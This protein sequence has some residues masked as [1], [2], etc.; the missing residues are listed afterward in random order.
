MKTKDKIILVL[1][2][3][4]AAFLWSARLGNLPLWED[5][6]HT[7]LLGKSILTHPLPTAWDGK[8]L[9]SGVQAE[10]FN[11]NYV[12]TWD[13][14][15][16]FYLTAASFKIFGINSTSAR[17]PFLIC[18]LISIFLLFLLTYRLTEKPKLALLTAFTFALEILYSLAHTHLYLTCHIQ[19]V[20]RP[21]PMP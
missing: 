5:E 7:A 11:S 14:P 12:I 21:L 1:I 20:H 9:I 18:G 19:Q 15:L 17:L 4:F 10:G 2:L 6:A 13:Q 3:L 8:N 16:Q